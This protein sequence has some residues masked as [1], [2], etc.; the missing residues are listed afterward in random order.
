MA[1][2]SVE[3]DTR[4]SSAQIARVC[5]FSICSNN[6]IPNVEVLFESLRR[7]HSDFDLFLC[8]VD[9]TIGPYG[10]YEIIQAKDLGIDDFDSFSFQYDIM[11]LNTAVKPFMF[12][13]LLKQLSYDQVIYFD[14]DIQLFGPLTTVLDA[15]NQGASF[16]LTP[17]LLQPAEN[18]AEPDDV[19]IMRAG[20]YNMGFM[21]CSSQAETEPIL[22]WWA[23]RLLH[24]CVSE[25]DHGLF[26]DQKFIDLVP[27]FADHVRILRDP[28]LNVAYWNLQ[29]RNLS[30]RGDK[31]IVDGRPLKFFHFSGLDPHDTSILSK[32]TRHFRG[33]DIEP[34]LRRLMNEYCEKCRAHAANASPAAAYAYGRFASGTPI[35]LFVREMFRSQ[36]VPWDGN[37]FENYEAFLHDAAIGTNGESAAFMI[38]NLMHYSWQRLSFLR[39]T[40]DL[41]TA[42]GVKSFTHWFI[43]HAHSDLGLD[44]RLVEP[45]AVRAGRSSVAVP[46]S[47]DLNCPPDVTVVGYLRTVSGIG[48]IGRQMLRTLSSTTLRVDGYDV[49]LNVAAVRSDSSCEDALVTASAGR[50]QIL[51][52]NADQLPEVLKHIQPNTTRADY[53][54]AIPFWELEEFPEPLVSSFDDINE[55]WAPSR[56]IQIA[57]M[58]KLTKPVIHMPMNLTFEAPAKFGRRHFSLPE[59]RFL[60]FFSFDF[61]SYQERKNPRGL[62]AAFRRAFH[63]GRH[64]ATLVLKTMNGESRREDLAALQE[65]LSGAKDVILIDKTMTRAQNLALI[66]ACD[67]VATLH[68]SEG[69]GLLVAEA[70]TLGKPVISTDY[71]ATT[72]FVTPATG[73]PVDHRLIPV[74]KDQYPFAAGMWADPD[75]DHAAWLMRRLCDNPQIAAAKVSRAKAFIAENHGKRPT[76]DLYLARLREL[77]L[78]ASD[79]S[80]NR[81]RRK[82]I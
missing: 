56:F 80:T 5:A 8:L 10:D 33:D 76:A 23:R 54:V 55:I 9:E 2:K 14:P 68:R 11:E 19:A 48:E 6:Y 29:Q 36:H 69:L 61:L 64:P 58:R 21:A 60:F 25:P 71:S 47:V 65:E 40:F 77:G 35:Q 39:D 42:D 75:L 28:T 34:P 24:Q 46:K 53:R 50:V 43:K 13:K 7:V 73:F 44:L 4:K 27:G 49:A 62:L 30:R 74:E 32:H 16:V 59:D 51:G 78:V 31:W 81:L 79:T 18:D 52:V 82:V 3:F 70:M 66:D 67:C 12:L 20:T 72:E 38:T 63:K 1:P 26:V 17:H 45:I 37:P 41:H 15:L 57:L 22:R